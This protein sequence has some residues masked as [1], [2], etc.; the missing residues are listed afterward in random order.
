MKIVHGGMAMALVVG[1]PVLAET[2]V[3]ME[4]PVGVERTA[5]IGSP[6][7]EKFRFDAVKVGMADGDVVKGTLT[8]NITIRAGEPLYQVQSKAR[9]KACSQSGPC[10]LDD[11]GDG[12]FDRI[13]L[14]DT[15]AALRLKAPVRYQIK[16]AVA[17]SSS[18]NFKQV[19]SYLGVSGDTLRFSYREFLN[20]MARPAFTEEL[21]FPIT[22][23]YP[24]G[25]AFKD[26]KMTILGIDGMGLRYRLEQ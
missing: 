25:V 17:P 24:Q 7:V 4:P 23:T 5:T 26:V 11:D 15:V 20:D 12:T 16:D 8:G 21:T 10:A 22:K 2:K 3:G 1:A 6:V 14:D 13:A 18:G 19:V 9:Y